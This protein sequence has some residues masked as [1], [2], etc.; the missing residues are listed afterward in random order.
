[1]INIMEKIDTT[2]KHTL[3]SN[4]NL[5]LDDW[6]EDL[7]ECNPDLSEEELY[8]EMCKVN[9]DYLDDLRAEV[10]DIVF[11]TPILEDYCYDKDSYLMTDDVSVDESSDI[12]VT[13]KVS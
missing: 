7:Q 11:D 13:V 9:D 6:R 1:M 2:A 5:N 8:E 10:K 12:T 3:W 4:K